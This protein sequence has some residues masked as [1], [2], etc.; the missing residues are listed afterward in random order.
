MATTKTPKK[1]PPRTPT[2]PG[3]RAI[4]SEVVAASP[5]FDVDL[6]EVDWDLLVDYLEDEEE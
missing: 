2:P 5:D 3:L 4:V 1:S 6:D